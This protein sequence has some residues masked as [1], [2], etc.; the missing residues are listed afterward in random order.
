[1][2][3]QEPPEL[4]HLWRF[5][6][7]YSAIILDRYKKRCAWALMV[8]LE[9]G[10]LHSFEPPDKALEIPMHRGNGQS[11][12]HQSVS[13]VDVSILHA[14]IIPFRIQPRRTQPHNRLIRLA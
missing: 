5:F 13:T 14:L 1:M 2:K 12:I 8:K 9:Y 3:Q 7:L 6:W 4:L 11:G 10:N